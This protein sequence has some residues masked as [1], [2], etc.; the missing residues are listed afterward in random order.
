MEINT[1]FVGLLA[2]GLVASALAY[3]ELQAWQGL[4]AVGLYAVAGLIASELIA[5]P[6]MW[7]LF[8]LRS[9]WVESAAMS[10]ALAV[11]L[12]RVCRAAA[13]LTAA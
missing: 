12:W 3:G 11:G 7:D 2:C 1:L 13:S 6:M 9:G 4:R 5:A 8:G 10:T